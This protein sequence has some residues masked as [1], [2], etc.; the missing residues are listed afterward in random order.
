MHDGA[1]HEMDELIRGLTQ[2]PQ[3][4]RAAHYDPYWMIENQMGL[5]AL[6]LAEFLC[7][8]V[9]IEQGMRVLDLGCGRAT[10][11][12]FLAREFGCTVFAADAGIDP[13]ENSRR[14]EEY[15]MSHL[16]FPLH[17]DARRLPFAQGY[18]DV[19]LCIDSFIYFGTDDLYL[20]YLRRF[21]RPGGRIGVVH[22]CLVN[23]FGNGVPEHLRPFWGQDCWSWHKADWWRHLWE[24]TG[25]VE[26]SS[27]DS[28]P[29]GCQIYADWKQCRLLLAQDRLKNATSEKERQKLEQSISSIAVDME[30]LR[31]DQGRYVGFFRMAARCPEQS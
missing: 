23:E 25:L 10:A 4:P 16:V 3:F 15:E 20:D 6:W 1:S 28:M 29:E 13:S 9:P 7:E 26:I 22:P 12:I 14:I 11:S 30:L 17:A 18:F 27:V 21:I 8:A 31:E 2:K 19:I 24:R 5:N